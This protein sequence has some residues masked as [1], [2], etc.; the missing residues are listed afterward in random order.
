M[1]TERIV[2]PEAL[3]QAVASLRER[4]IKESARTVYDEL[5]GGSMTTIA[6]LLRE[7]RKLE[8]QQPAQPSEP[9]ALPPALDAAMRQSAGEMWKA[10]QHE[11]AVMVA[12]VKAQAQNDVAQAE[13]ERDTHLGELEG[14]TRELEEARA[15]I[16][17]LEEAALAQ[18]QE[19]ASERIARNTAETRTNELDKHLKELQADVKAERGRRDEAEA[20]RR[21]AE[22]ALSAC[23]A[24]TARLTE[25]VSGLTQRLTDAGAELARARELSD[26]ALRDLERRHGE[27]LARMEAK[28]AEVL[29]E[30]KRRSLETID[31]LQKTNQRLESEAQDHIAA[32]RSAAEKAGRLQGELDAL[33]GGEA[34]TA[35][36]GK[37]KK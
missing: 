20:G 24:E 31:K 34:G 15:K 19:L 1:A 21:A 37:A 12:A 5:G 29:G 23:Q 28:H 14:A 32:A 30:Q 9:V 35:P 36:G 7:F 26:Q 11:C 8:A 25:Q 33:K 3:K 10:A 22:Q 4:G 17:A 6:N 16:R 18:G 13:A 27:E 2:T